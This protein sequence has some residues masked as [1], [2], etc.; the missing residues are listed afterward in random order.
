MLFLVFLP[1]RFRE[2][3]PLRC[4]FTTAILKCLIYLLVPLH[5]VT[6]LIYAS[7]LRRTASFWSWLLLVSRLTILVNLLMNLEKFF[8]SRNIANRETHE[9]THLADDASSLGNFSAEFL[10]LQGHLVELMV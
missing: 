7:I 1:I 10:T 6:L 4:L 3:L 8:S 9:I 5:A 2:D